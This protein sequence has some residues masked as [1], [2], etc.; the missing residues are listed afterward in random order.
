MSSKSIEEQLR[1]IKPLVTQEAPADGSIEGEELTDPIKSEIGTTFN[2]HSVE[3]L[4]PVFTASNHNIY[5]KRRTPGFQRKPGSSAS[6]D[7]LNG[8]T[9]SEEDI[10]KLVRARLDLTNAEIAEKKS[11]SS[12]TWVL[13]AMFAIAGVS[14]LAMLGRNCVNSDDS[15]KFHV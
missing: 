5:E 7:E 1:D 2:N 14:C 8:L 13:T 10:R 15:P 6:G 4:E 9:L 11:S 12:L 3:V